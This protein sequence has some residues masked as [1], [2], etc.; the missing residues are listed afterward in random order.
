M[1]WF[2]V[3]H[4]TVCAWRKAFGV[5]QWGTEG[6]KRLQLQNSAAGAD[7][8]RGKRQPKRMIRL[9]ILTRKAYCS[10]SG[11]RWS[12]EEVWQ[13]EEL[14]LLGTLPDDEV[15]ARIGRTTNAVRIKRT[16]LGIPNV[17]DRRRR[18]GRSRR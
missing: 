6:S 18:Q 1:H 12:A 9:R 3:S 13:P 4:N 10:R 2:G 8:I 16:K 11:R 7:A 15:A 17:R 14:A 5:E